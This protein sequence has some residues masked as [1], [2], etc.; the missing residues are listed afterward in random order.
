MS[1]INSLTWLADNERFLTIN[2]KLSDKVSLTEEESSFC[3]SVAI[4]LIKE[5][6]KD[7]RRTSYLE[8]GYFLV[9]N[10]SLQSGN[11]EPLFDL[12]I[13]LGFYP[14]SKYIVENGMI[15]GGKFYHYFINKGLDDFKYKEITETLEQKK[16]R[17]QIISTESKDSCYIAPTS[18]GKSSMMVELISESNFSKVFIIVPTKSLLT[19]TYKVINSNF[20]KRKVI[21]HDEMY[22]GEENFIAV[23]TQERALR[24]LKR[25]D[26]MKVDALLVDE[27]H[28]LFELSSRSILLS[29]LIR[30]V[31]VRDENSRIFYFSPLICDSN[32]LKFEEQQ[33][34]ESKRIQFNIKEPNINEYRLNSNIYKYN[35]FLNRFF[36]SGSGDSLV[37]YIFNNKKENNFIYLRAP[38]KVEGFA[39]LLAENLP[40]VKNET[41]EKLSVTISI[42]VHEDFYCVELVKKGII[43]IHGKL[44]DLIKEY[45]EYKFRQV[46]ELDFIVANAVILEG[47]NLPIDNLY[48]LNTYSL[49]AKGLTNLIGRVNRLNEVFGGETP[50]LEKLLPTVHFVNSEEFNKANSNMKNKIE[51]LKSGGFY[52]EVKN[53]TLL[54]FD[55]EKYDRIIEESSSVVAIDSAKRDRNNALSIIDRENFLTKKPLNEL[56]AMKLQFFESSIHLMY[57][58][59][60]ICF[61]RIID[62][63]ESF[64]DVEMD[65]IDKIYAIFIKGFE[66][67]IKDLS[68]ARLK[69]EKA[70]NFYKSFLKNIHAL[71]LKEHINATV[72]YFY[73]NSV[74]TGRNIFYIGESYGEVDKFGSNDGVSTYIDLT[75]KSH[76]ELV[77]LALVKIKMESDFLSYKLNNFVSLLSDY[78]FISEYEYNIFIYGTSKKRNSDLIKLGFS[79]GIIRKFEADGQLENIKVDEFGHVFV[80]DDFSAYLASQDDLIKF[81]VNKYISIR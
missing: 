69:N 70:R 30:R 17:S 37:S 64:E 65:L 48:I 39:G 33:Q 53:P 18:F 7:R 20:P 50:S 55:I 36:K 8:F 75:T 51:L 73:A 74:E 31:R 56:E 26:T 61:D 60:E 81:E 14:I 67:D 2:K 27:A 11:Y 71:T 28:N 4:L 66:G 68:I 76:K 44:P 24:L 47:V 40:F 45:L 57:S 5:Y 52:D 38:R 58:D 9:L 1:Q 29:R 62:N 12:S 32:N 72:K 13:N 80:N 3:L 49:N 35:R 15:E 19:Q 16:Y 63:I 77:N 78:N 34:I 21:F 79:G 6:E 23:F 54:N 22:G 25:E 42:N 46:D 59:A 43:Y 10:Y 41:L